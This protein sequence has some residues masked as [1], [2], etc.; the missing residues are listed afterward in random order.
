MT[1]RLCCAVALLAAPLPLAAQFHLAA[2][3]GAATA[4]GHARAPDEP[5]EPVLRPDPTRDAA[6]SAGMDRAGWRL[7]ARAR[8]THADL[9]IRDDEAGIVTVDVLRAT[10][11]GLEVGRRLVGTPTTPALWLSGGVASERWSF[12]EIAEEARTRLLLTV[13]LEG[14]V[15][16]GA[17]FQGTVRLE[18]GSSPSAF[19]TEELP[20]GFAT[21]RARRGAMHV[22]IRWRP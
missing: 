18:A 21:E 17:R 11:L 20:E 6:I 3:A 1:T 12:P 9:V 7:A 13:A 2:S 4:A 8:R 15:P 16:L 19:T 5:G 22:G 10:A 14:E